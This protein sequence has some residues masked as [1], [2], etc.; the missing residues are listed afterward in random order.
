M[1]LSFF[2]FQV[3]LPYI[4]FYC[5]YLQHGPILPFYY[6]QIPVPAPTN[7]QRHALQYLLHFTHTSPTYVQTS[8]RNSLPTN[9]VPTSVQ[10][11]KNLASFSRNSPIPNSFILYLK[12]L[13]L[14]VKTVTFMAN[15][16]ICTNAPAYIYVFLPKSLKQKSTSML[17]Y[18]LWYRPFII[19]GLQYIHK[20][21]PHHIKKTTF[22]KLFLI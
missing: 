2:S 1:H 14:H 4:A 15:F 6:Q 20:T 16:T 21:S 10:S 5:T 22:T 11:L 8:F 13:T 12:R 7:V 18:V 3:I 17:T 9:C 19:N